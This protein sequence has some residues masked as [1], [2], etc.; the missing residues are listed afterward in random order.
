MFVSVI[1]GKEIRKLKRKELWLM[2]IR[3][4]LTEPLAIPPE[5]QKFKHQTKLDIGNFNTKAPFKKAFQ[6]RR[7]V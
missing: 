5:K 6:C 7:Q 4:T 2:D 3:K 1:P